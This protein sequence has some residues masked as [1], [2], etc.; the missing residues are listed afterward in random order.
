MTP[1]LDTGRA[2]TLRDY[3]LEDREK[4]VRAFLEQGH[5]RVLGVW[6]TASGK[7]VMFSELH[8]EQQM[9]SWL[10][11]YPQEHQKILVLAHRTELLAQAAA[12]LAKSNPDLF[13]DIDQ[14][15]KQ[16][17]PFADVVVASIQTLTA[18]RGKRLRRLDPDQYRI[19]IVD[20]AHHAASPSYHVVLQH[21]GFLP[22]PHFAQELKPEKKDGKEKRLKWQ[23]DRLDRWDA[24]YRPDRLLLG[25]TAT[26]KR[27]DNIGLEAVFQEI[28]FE[29]SIREMV[30]KGYL[31]PLRAFRVLSG[32]SLE[33]VATRA[34]DFAQDE[35][36]K[37]VNIQDRNAKAVRAYLDY[38]PGLKGITFCANVA[39]SYSMAAA[40]NSAGVPAAVIHGGLSEAYRAQILQAFVAGEIRMLTNCNVLTEGVDI[41]DIQVIIH[42][43][44]TKSSLLYIQM[45]GRGFR[46]FPGK[47]YCVIIDIVD[48]TRKHS[49]FTSPEL[50]GLPADFDAK[51]QDL[52]EAK[53]FVEGIA[54]AHPLA[55]VT[56]VKAIEDCQIRVTEVDLLGRFH[57]EHIDRHA[58]LAWRKTGDGYEIDWRGELLNEAVEIQKDGEKWKTF[59]RKGQREVWQKE[60]A[61]PEAALKAG[62]QYLK[63]NLAHI[64]SMN[65]RDTSWVNLPATNNQK[66]LVEGFYRINTETL[67][68][69]QARDLISAYYSDKRKGL[70]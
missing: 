26:S 66:L 6:P 40:F 63:T 20:E 46:I 50:F 13:I 34:G 5:T 36:A 68:K 10:K 25:V 70:K 65:Q 60:S 33:E 69:G 59:Y 12:K 38:A 9:A 22:P 54:A 44:P 21:F 45:T 23:R 16:A 41:P 55:D 19:V 49:L 32:T 67:T 7:T 30:E 28:A 35:L 11:Q 18:T 17:S 39:H 4:V 42:A 27:G 51:G 58:S 64:H 52:L 57:D 48:I 1:L 31:C 2:V 15:G 3:Q 14:A 43:R 53:R 8:L 62:E 24:S 61:T 37:A 47:P 29:R 56:D